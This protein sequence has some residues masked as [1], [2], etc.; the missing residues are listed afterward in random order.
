MSSFILILDREHLEQPLFMKLFAQK[1]HPFKNNRLLI[2]HSD[3]EYTQRLIENGAEPKKAKERAIKEINQKLVSLLAD[4]GIPALGFHGFH[5]NTVV[6]SKS[7]SFQVDSTLLKNHPS[8]VALLFS[9]L[10][11][12]EEAQTTSFIEPA[13]LALLLKNELNYDDIF[14]FALTDQDRKSVV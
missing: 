13:E 9:T 5:R 11:S 14:A 6:K 2:I 1:L 4:N 12:D 3:S 7:G 10:I 8:S